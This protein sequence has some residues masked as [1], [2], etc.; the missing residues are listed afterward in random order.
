M[1]FSCCQDSEYTE[2]TWLVEAA[3]SMRSFLMAC[4]LS[5][6]KTVAKVSR[7]HLDQEFCF[8]QGHRQKTTTLSHR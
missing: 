2:V 6:N 1:K 8:H 7:S 4:C 5:F 3:M